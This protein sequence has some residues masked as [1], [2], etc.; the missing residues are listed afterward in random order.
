MSITAGVI[1][2]AHT[3]PRPF[4]RFIA[5]IPNLWGIRGSIKYR[6]SVRQVSPYDNNAR[7]CQVST[8]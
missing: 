7:P 5:D 6:I 1:R 2:L 8:R 4:L 3:E